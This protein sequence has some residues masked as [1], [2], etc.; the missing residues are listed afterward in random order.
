VKPIVVRAMVACRLEDL[1]DM[2]TRQPS[3]WMEPFLRIAAHLGDTQGT[4][5]ALKIGRRPPAT[6]LPRRVHIAVRPA[7]H[8]VGAATAR[9]VLPFRWHTDGYHTVFALLD[10]RMVLRREDEART[11][12]VIEGALDPPKWLEDLA[13]S[14]IARRTASETVARFLGSL[15][16]AIAE[17]GRMAQTI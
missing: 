9:A 2:L 1:T 3:T 6:E 8:K 14:V 7:N 10:G 5:L 11:S 13:G 15:E 12:I 16:A 17:M 4:A